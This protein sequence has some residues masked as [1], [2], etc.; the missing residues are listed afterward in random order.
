[1]PYEYSGNFQQ[2]TRLKYVKAPTLTKPTGGGVTQIELPKAGILGG[3]AVQI[4]ATVAGSLSAPNAGGLASIIKRIQLRVNAGQTIFDM[5]GVGYAYL[6]SQFI[7]DN[8]DQTVGTDLQLAVTTGTKN[9]DIFLPVAL[10]TRDELGLIM[11]QNMQTIV[12]LIIEWEADATVATGAT[13][14]ATA[15]PVMWVYEVPSNPNDIPP[16][17]TIH[18]VLETASTIGG[19]GDSDYQI[20]IG[21][22]LVGVYHLFTAGFTNAQLRVQQSNVIFDVSAAQHAMLYKL[23]TSRSINLTGTAITGSN[24]RIMWDL[25]GTDGLG[26]FGSV[27]DYIDTQALTSIFTRITAVGSGSLITQQRQLVNLV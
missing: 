21:S 27:R 8:Y 12:T 11:L 5:S 20:S 4:S 23:V 18:Q 13:V 15:N 22:T 19:A 7:Q 26:Q 24:N 25:G 9:L 6:L 16:L 3:L 1:M 17:D 2:N 10:N 14:T